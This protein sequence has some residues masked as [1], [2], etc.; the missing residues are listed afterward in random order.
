MTRD[1]ARQRWREQRGMEPGRLLWPV[2]RGELRRGKTMATSGI[3]HALTQRGKQAKLAHL[4]PHDLRRTCATMMRLGGDDILKIRNY[5][6]HESV[7]TTALYL[8][9]DL[10]ARR[11]EVDAIFAGIGR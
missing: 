2:L 9:D 1:E 5:L 4:S 11:R 7:D 10:D 6:G 8:R 3:W